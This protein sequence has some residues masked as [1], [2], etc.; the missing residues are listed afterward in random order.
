MLVGGG[1]IVCDAGTGKVIKKLPIQTNPFEAGVERQLILHAVAFA[2]GGKTAIS[3]E[4]DGAAVVWDVAQGKPIRQISKCFDYGEAVDFSSG[5][6]LMVV[7]RSYP[8]APFYGP[9]ECGIWDTA[10]GKKVVSFQLEKIQAP[11]RFL[12]TED[13]CESLSASTTARSAS[14]TRRTAR[15]SAASRPITRTSRSRQ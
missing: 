12:F 13:K 5:G 9:H 1:G 8:R 11:R 10:T 6:A 3:A 7:S 14:W 4:R 2:E 15:K